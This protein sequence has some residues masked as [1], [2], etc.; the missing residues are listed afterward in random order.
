[1]KYLNIYE[2]AQA[3]GGPEE[4]GWW[5]TYGEPVESTAV[6]NL[7]QSI[8]TCDNLNAKFRKFKSGYAMGFGD[9]DGVCLLYTSPSPRD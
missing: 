1:M 7:R 4:G 9:H 8:K 2:L 5:Y 3:Y 6:I